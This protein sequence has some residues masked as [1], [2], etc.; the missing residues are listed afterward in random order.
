MACF[1][2]SS[3]SGQAPPYLAD[4][5]YTWFQKAQDVGFARPPTD[6]ACAVPRTQHIG[7]R[8]SFAAAEPRIWNSLPVHLRD[9]DIIT[10]FGVNLK[11]FGFNVASGAQ[12]DILINCDINAL[13]KL[14]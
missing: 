6:R 7:D 4:G 9:E 13:T 3:L 1:V 11:R 14:N 12:C 5:I 10:V 2:Y 8:V